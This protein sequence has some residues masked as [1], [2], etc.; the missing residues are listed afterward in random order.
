MEVLAN[1]AVAEICKLVDDGYAVLRLE[2]SESRKENKALKRKLQMMELRV[3]RGGA[4]RDEA[5]FQAA[6]RVFGKL[7]DTGP[8]RGGDANLSAV[9]DDGSPA[10]PV[11]TWDECEDIEEGRS[12]SVPVKE[13]RVEEDGDPQRGLKFPGQ[14]A[15]DL[16]ADGGKRDP[17]VD[18]QSRPAQHTE[19]LTEQHR[20]RHSAWESADME[21]GRTESLLIK[22]ERLEEDSDPQGELKIREERVVESDTDGDEKASSPGGRSEPGEQLAEQHRSR[23]SAW[24]ISGLEAALATD[25]ESSGTSRGQQHERLSSL[26]SEYV[27]YERAAPLRVC[28]PQADADLEAEDPTCSF[29]AETKAETLSSQAEPKFGPPAEEGAASSSLGPLDWR[30]EAAMITSKT[31]PPHPQLTAR[32]KPE[33]NPDAAGMNGLAP[34]DGGYAAFKS[35]NTHRRASTREKRFFCSFCGKGFSFPKQVEIHQRVHTGEKPFSCTQCRQRFSH[36]GNLKRHQRVHTGEKPFSCTL[37]EKR[38]SHLHQLKMHQRIHTGERPF[39]CAHCGKRF[40]ERSYLRIHQQ[41]SHTGVY[42]VR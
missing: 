18:T 31:R 1:A 10:N 34:C 35:N 3:A 29:P 17:T 25:P 24:E 19:E 5:H 9:D 15:V 26:F 22:E 39:G 14:K 7:V 38:F 13:E 12:E 33:S 40:S 37:C 27:I 11:I 20:T 8:R 42:S 36:S 23:L 41:R 32:E 16:D 6:E 4:G 2:I 28:F 30:P 21:E